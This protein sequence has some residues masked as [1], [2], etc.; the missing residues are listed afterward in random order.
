MS[1]QQIQ[2]ISGSGTQIRQITPQASV[3]RNGASGD[4]MSKFRESFQQKE[5]EKKK[6]NKQGE[7][8]PQMYMRRR[9]LRVIPKEMMMQELKTQQEKKRWNDTNNATKTD[10]DIN[11]VNGN[12]NR[13]MQAAKKYADMVDEMRYL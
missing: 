11:V 1:I 6:E 5:Q 4:A 2:N 8:L 10:V 9:R 3:V 7:G 13:A 12:H